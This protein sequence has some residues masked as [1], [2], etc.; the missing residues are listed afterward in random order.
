M[1]CFVYDFFF[2]FFL[3]FVLGVLD[4]GSIVS[5]QVVFELRVWVFERFELNERIVQCFGCS[6]CSC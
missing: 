4:A 3:A 2:F 5:R 6:V 1:D